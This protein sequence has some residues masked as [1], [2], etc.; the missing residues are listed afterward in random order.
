[1]RI[2]GYEGLTGTDEAFENLERL[3]GMGFGLFHV[4][5]RSLSECQEVV[6]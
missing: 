1:M 2:L 4:E 3:Q 6:E 5:R